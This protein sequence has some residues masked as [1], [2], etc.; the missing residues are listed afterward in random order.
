[1]IQQLPGCG[2]DPRVFLNVNLFISEESGAV[3][4]EVLKER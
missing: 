1:M 4:T 2:W 3:V